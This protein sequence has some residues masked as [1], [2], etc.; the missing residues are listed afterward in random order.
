MKYGASKELWEYWVQY[1]NLCLKEG[2]LYRTRQTEPSFEIVYQ[3]HVPWDR[4][5]N[6]LLLYSPRAGHFGIKKLYQRACEK[7]YWPC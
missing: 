2:L 3:M 4:V 1:K 7:V 6:V 5:F